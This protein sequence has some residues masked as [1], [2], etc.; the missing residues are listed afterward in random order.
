M[1][2]G[3]RDAFD[4]D[5]Y[6]FK[7]AAVA[8]E[9]RLH[10]RLDVTY[11]MF[12]RGKPTRSYFVVGG[13][14]LA[15]DALP[16]FR[17]RED[18]IQYLCRHPHIERVSPDFFNHLR[19]WRFKGTIRAMPEGTVAFANEPLMEITTDPVSATLVECLL[20]P[21]V[22]TVTTSATRCRAS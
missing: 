12:S 9:H 13:T 17:F 20:S 8:F 16:Y 18:E 19:T 1:Q 14:S 21:L 2:L 3:V 15:I 22:D 4:N 7:M 5:W 6:K 10:E 11:A